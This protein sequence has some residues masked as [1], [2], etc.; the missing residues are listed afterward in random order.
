MEVFDGLPQPSQGDLSVTR[1]RFF[2]Y[3]IDSNK[4]LVISLKSQSSNKYRILAK[5][6]GWEEYINSSSTIIYPMYLQEEYP[7]ADTAEIG[8]TALILK[9]SYFSQ[10]LKTSS[11]LLIAVYANSPTEVAT[12][13]NIEIMQKVAKLRLS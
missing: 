2:Y 5:I 13:F 3:A 10:F 7:H 9:D 12:N 1:G 11:V 6:V 8:T 4:P